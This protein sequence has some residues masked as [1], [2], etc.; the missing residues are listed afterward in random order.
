MNKIQKVVACLSILTA[1][2]VIA[3]IG[4]SDMVVFGDSLSDPGNVFVL[5]GKVS[6]RP[7]NAGNIPDAPYP[8]GGLTFSNGKTWVEHVSANLKLKGG[9]GPA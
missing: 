8:I 5:E 3:D 9:N 1:P 7:Y 4:Y 6:V 2:A